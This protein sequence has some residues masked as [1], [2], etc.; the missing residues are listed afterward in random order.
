[1]NALRPWV[2]AARPPTLWASAAPVAV[3]AGLAW[4]E[5]VFRLDALLVAM[6]AAL[7]INIGANLA[8]DASDARR[9]ADGPARVG[10]L[11][12]V[13]SGLLTPRQVWSGVAVVFALA[14]LGGVYLAV[15]A[16]WPVL[17]IGAASL[18]AA[19][20]YTGGPRPYGYLGLGEAAVFVFFGLAATVGSR[21]VHDATAPTAAWLLAVPM[22]FTV[23]AILVANNVRDVDTD[24]EAGKRTLAVTLGRQ[25]GRLLY[26]ALM[27]GA[28]LALTIEAAVGAVPRLCLLGLLAVPAA[29][30]VIAAVRRETEG[31]ALVRALRA[32]ARVHALFG[33]LVA[34]GS[35][36]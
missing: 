18:A 27:A 17:A 14:S 35:A 6:T 26:T 24:R 2:Q 29:L 3:G 19:L 23:T 9:G 22:G 28:F 12:A 25:G 31:P 13:A 7:L 16:G 34:V 30:P 10:P 8:N 21:F 36:I 32:T 5:G 1:V 11:R 4:G 15:I 20:A 33:L